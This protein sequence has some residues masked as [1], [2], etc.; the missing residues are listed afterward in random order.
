MERNIKKKEAEF[1]PKIKHSLS[2]QGESEIKKIAVPILA[3]LL[4]LTSHFV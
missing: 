4:L 2:F 1:G 3:G